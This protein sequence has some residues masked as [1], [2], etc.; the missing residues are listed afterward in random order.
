M[1]MAVMTMAVMTMAVMMMAVTMM[2]VTMR[3][4][5]KRSSPCSFG[6]QSAQNRIPSS[7]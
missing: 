7:A 4:A 3:L 5:M 6:I 2:A 1:T